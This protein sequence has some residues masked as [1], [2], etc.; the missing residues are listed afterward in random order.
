M[1]CQYNYFQIGLLAGHLFLLFKERSLP[2]FRAVVHFFHH[3]TVAKDFGRS[4]GGDRPYEIAAPL[5]LN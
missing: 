1:I 5:I 2:F 3:F 4:V